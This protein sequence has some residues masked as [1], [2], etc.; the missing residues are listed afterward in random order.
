MGL[1][2]SIH[3]DQASAIISLGGTL[4]ATGM[5][6]LRAIVGHLHA[7]GCRRFVLDLSKLT[8]V[9]PRQQRQLAALIGQPLFTPQAPSC[10]VR[11]LADAS[12]A[13]PQ[14]GCRGPSFLGT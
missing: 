11:Q 13:R 8:P 1:H 12:A 9:T 7:R 10:A 5:V 6:Q 4:R 3:Q 2:A 14:P